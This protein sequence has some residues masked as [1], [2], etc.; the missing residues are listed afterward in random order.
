MTNKELLQ[1]KLNN[2]SESIEV[3]N[4]DSRTK[5]KDLLN[6][7]INSDL[8]TEIDFIINEEVL[9]ILK[10]AETYVR[11]TIPGTEYDESIVMGYYMAI[12]R[13]EIY[14]SQYI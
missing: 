10:K 13:L 8:V 9:A 7:H 14:M 3:E 11:E 1:D 6:K 2:I 5:I 12:N 4:I